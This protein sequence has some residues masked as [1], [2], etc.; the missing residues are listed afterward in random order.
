MD[1]LPKVLVLETLGKYSH[2]VYHACHSRMFLNQGYGEKINL[3][4]LNATFDFYKTG[5]FALDVILYQKFLHYSGRVHS[6]E[7]AD[8]VFVPFLF[9]AILTSGSSGKCRKLKQS[10]LGEK[11]TGPGLTRETMN[12]VL[13]PKFVVEMLAELKRMK[14]GKRVVIMSM[15]RTGGNNYR[16]S[17]LDKRFE[18]DLKNFRFLGIENWEGRYKQ[19]IMVPY[20]TIFHM[21]YGATPQLPKKSS[22]AF[23]FYGSPR[24]RANKTAR[25]TEP[26]PLKASVAKL[27]YAI[28]DALLQRSD[29]TIQI[30]TRENFN[31]HEAYRA[32]AHSQFCIQPPGD[33]PTRRGFYDSVLLGCIPVVFSRKAYAPFG[34]STKSIA[35]QL[36][37]HVPPENIVD[38]LRN[39]SQ[40]NIQD[41]QVKILKEMCAFQYSIYQDETHDAFGNILR[42]LHGV[43]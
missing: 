34:Q 15:A 25:A 23:L 17:F 12:K 27:R 11:Y 28:L 31:L 10:M 9:Q 13:L 20:P 35:I 19:I 39:I 42:V 41:M 36:H 22:S 4:L 30:L 21:R 14:S 40:T 33:S 26:P 3:D 24:L 37:E 2:E 16:Q 32:M 6:M 43:L 8:L 38:I 7:E 1:V 29:S 5:Q 18:K